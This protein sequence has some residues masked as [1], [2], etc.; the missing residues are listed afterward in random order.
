MTSP[1]LRPPTSDL[2]PAEFVI[3]GGGAVGC[4]MAYALAKAGHTDVLVIEKEPSLCNVTSSQGAGLC[5]QIRSSA[6]RTRLAMFSARTFKE[7]EAAGGPARPNWHAVGSLRLAH[8]DARVAEF[9]RLKQ[10]SDEVG[11]E[12]ELIDIGRAKKLWPN[13][14]FAGIQAVLWCPTDGYMDPRSVVRTYE[15]H[16]RQLGVRFATD[17]ALAGIELREGRVAAVRTSRGTIDCRFAINA[18]GAHAYH[19][20]KLVGLELP[21]VPV[22][23]EYFVS[24][25]LPGMHPGLPVLR[26]PDIGLYLRA[27]GEGL[28][29]GGWEETAVS[30]NPTGF[31]LTDEPPLNADQEVL[32]GF[33]ERMEPLFPGVRDAASARVAKGWPTFTPDG[34][35]IVGES[36]RV[37]G[38]VMAGGCNAH[39]ISGSP[40]LGQHLVEALFSPQ[41]S[42]YIKSLSPDRFDG[43]TWDWETVRSQAEKIYREYYGIGC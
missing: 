10:V 5:G 26:I 39:G 23:H 27:D 17:T 20:A 18:A 34:R 41:P 32:A 14:T 35:F 9:A 13:M 8:S 30:T 37:P 22:R 15:H 7:L 4:G 33:A 21:I 40:G 42:P 24:V 1:D 31:G 11:L 25:P 28:L 19:V 3:I 43:Q 29:V 16:S 2:S 12:V 36:R 6:E 38:F